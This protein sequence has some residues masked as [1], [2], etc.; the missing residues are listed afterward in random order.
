MRTR[1]VTG[2]V[3]ALAVLS[4]TWSSRAAQA[5]STIALLDQYLAGDFSAVVSSLAALE[6][7]DDTLDALD[8]NGPAW[9]DAGGAGER[10]RRE[11]AA[12]TFALEAARLGEWKAW[13]VIG[14]LP[15]FD[16]PGSTGA[17]PNLGFVPPFAGLAGVGG[18]G[19]PLEYKMYWKAPPL[20]IEWACKR[21]GERSPHA[22]WERTWFLASIGVAQRS[23]DPEFQTGH[24]ANQGVQRTGAVI[25][26]QQLVGPVI[27]H[28]RHAQVL[29]P[30]DARFS[31]AAG[32]GEEWHNVRAAREVFE[33][34]QDD[35][36]VG[37]EASI[38][39]GVLAWRDRDYGRAT[40]LLRR[41]ETKTIDPWLLYLARYFSGQTAVGRKDLLEA[42]RLFR[43]ALEAMPRAQSASFALASV[44]AQ[45]GQLN[46]ASAVTDAA[47]GREPS[48][49][50][51]REYAH[52]DD[53]FWPRLRDRLRQEIHR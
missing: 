28:A 25:P 43:S 17:L 51:W 52:G 44:L 6:S 29:F 50:P 48:P 26:P 46:E 21:L 24:T 16:P 2:T 15:T 11:A 1:L 19:I 22:P 32:I 39:L 7:F 4:W 31:L 30:S 42:E 34:L 36:D 18:A 53:R 45:R 23:E 8:K 37:A 14:S 3:A 47:L 40:T 35:V 49:D 27:Q 33:R 10:E 13:R 41:A 9:I 20:L 12:A 5:P 38:R